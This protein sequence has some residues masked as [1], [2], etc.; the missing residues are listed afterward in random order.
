MIAAINPERNLISDIFNLA[1]KDLTSGSSKERRGAI[2][3]FEGFWSK[4]WAEL[5]EIDYAVIY[6]TYQQIASGEK[7]ID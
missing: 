1:Y 5:L 2:F 4:Y 3:F 6:R 7:V